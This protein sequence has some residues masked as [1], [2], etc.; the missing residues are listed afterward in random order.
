M[1]TRKI[2]LR[3]KNEDTEG[4]KYQYFVS[5]TKGVEVVTP[6]K[7]AATILNEGEELQVVNMDW[8]AMLAPKQK[9]KSFKEWSDEILD[10]NKS[11]GIGQ[12]NAIHL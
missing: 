7:N 11:I 10:F 6:F 12:K 9:E 8:K 3:R 1:K 2:I 5:C 4:D